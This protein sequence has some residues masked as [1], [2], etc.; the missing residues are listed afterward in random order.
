[1]VALPTPSN[2]GHEPRQSQSLIVGRIGAEKAFHL[3][4]AF[5]RR[6]SGASE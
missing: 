6:A 3:S 4:E 2:K 1:M 5:Y